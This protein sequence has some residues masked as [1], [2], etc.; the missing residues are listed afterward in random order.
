MRQ[1]MDELLNAKRLILGEAPEEFWRD[2]IG[3]VY[4]A[5]EQAESERGTL[6]ESVAH[7]FIP[8]R[9]RALIENRLPE[10]TTKHPTCEVESKSNAVKSAYHMEVTIGKLVYTVSTVT[11]HLETPKPAVFRSLLAK[12]YQL[13]LEG[14]GIASEPDDARYLIMTHGAP[15][16]KA[17]PSFIRLLMFDGDRKSGNLDLL[18]WYREQYSS[19]QVDTAVPMPQ[20]RLRPQRRVSNS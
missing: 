5:Y 20:P 7:D 12:R 13:P 1:P 11:S 3:I 18:T 17:E 15:A 16:E 9:R 10:L 2:Q 4:E 14:F 6:L 8:I 19:S